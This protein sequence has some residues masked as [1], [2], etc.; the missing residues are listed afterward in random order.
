MSEFFE[1]PCPG[2]K[3]I[4]VVDR[5]QGKVV[6]VRKPIVEDSSGDRFEDA[7][8]KVLGEKDTIARK[9][10]EAR[11]RERN[12]M[13]RLEAL[14]KEGLQRAKEEGPITKPYNPLEND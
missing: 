6:E 1:I 5:R 10:E 7:R 14:F 13:N 3:T 9:V 12:K 4:L 2:C 11:D 8:R